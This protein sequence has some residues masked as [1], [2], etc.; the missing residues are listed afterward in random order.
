MYFSVLKRLANSNVAENNTE[1]WCNIPKFPLMGITKVFLILIDYPST[2]TSDI[3][4]GLLQ[5]V[6]FIFDTPVEDILRKK[7]CEISKTGKNGVTR[8]KRS[9]KMLMTL[10]IRKHLLG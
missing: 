10:T 9:K 6:C 7:G 2:N 5:N 4:Q 3:L 1:Y 8:P